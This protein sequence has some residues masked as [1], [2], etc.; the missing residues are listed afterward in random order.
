MRAIAVSTCQRL[1]A[2]FG[3]LVGVVLACTFDTAGELTAVF[4][5]MAKSLACMTLRWSGFFVRFYG[6]F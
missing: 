6:D 1:I 4:R 5:H 2:G 3:A